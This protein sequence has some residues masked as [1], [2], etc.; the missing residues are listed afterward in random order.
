M[1]F[2]ID[3]GF[4]LFLQAVTF[5]NFTFEN[6]DLLLQLRDLRFFIFHHLLGVLLECAEIAID[7]IDAREAICYQFFEIDIGGTDDIQHGLFLQISGEGIWQRFCKGINDE[8]GI[9]A[10]ELL[11]I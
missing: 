8:D 4:L 9:G 7:I 5:F 2:E 1:G 10:C 11:A 6:G 3:G